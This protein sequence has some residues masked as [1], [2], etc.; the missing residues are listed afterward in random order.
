MAKYNED[1]LNGWRK[2]PS[3]TEETKLSNVERMIR[4]A[5]AENEVLKPMNIDIYGKGSYAN[6]TNVRLNSDIDICVCL[7]DTVFV[8]LPK[9]KKQEDLGY[10]DSSYKFADFKDTI[11]KALI[12]KFGTTEVTRNDKCITIKENSNRVEADVVP[13]F[14]YHRHDDNGSKHIGTK[15][16]SDEGYPIINYPKQHIDNAKKRTQ[17]L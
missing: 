7:S 17:K 6:D 8:Q 11:E 14:E 1:T 2:P 5:I 10:S 15:L 12:D 9:D 4:E 3:N 16:L 13:S